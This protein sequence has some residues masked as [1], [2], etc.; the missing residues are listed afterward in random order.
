MLVTECYNVTE[1]G[2]YKDCDYTVSCD[3]LRYGVYSHDGMTMLY[4]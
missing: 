3:E 1:M 4:L 2:Q